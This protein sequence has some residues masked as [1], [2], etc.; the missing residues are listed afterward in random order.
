MK[1]DN[2]DMK[3]VNGGVKSDLL[4]QLSGFKCPDCGSNDIDIG[5]LQPAP[6][7]TI[8]VYTCRNCGRSWSDKSVSSSNSG[9][10]Q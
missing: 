1:I 3:K 2:D 6:N 4:G 9:A 8:F 5:L 7:V 10:M